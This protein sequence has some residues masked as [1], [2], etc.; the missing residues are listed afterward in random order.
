MLLT[1]GLQ[2]HLQ[3]FPCHFCLSK[4]LSE[5]KEPPT[6]EEKIIVSGQK[7]FDDDTFNWLVGCLDKVDGNIADAFNRQTQQADST[8]NGEYVASSIYT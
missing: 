4:Q 7:P 8:G 6:E 5:C 1:S 3:K 2:L